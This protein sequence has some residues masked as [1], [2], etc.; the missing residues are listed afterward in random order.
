M[1]ADQ[2]PHALLHSLKHFRC[3]HE[4]GVILNGAFI[5]QPFVPAHRR[6]EA[7]ALGGRFHW[8]RDRFGLPPNQVMD[9]GA[10]LVP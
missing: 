2:V 10:Q 3:L 9:L 6:M 5:D 8:V 7:E 1:S 4:R